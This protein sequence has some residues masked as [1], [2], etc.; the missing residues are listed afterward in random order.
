M[1]ILVIQFAPA[2]YGRPVPR[3]EPQLGTLLALL[4]QRGHEL[5][6]AGMP[7]F[8]EQTIK[9]ALARSLPQLVYADID[10]VCSDAARRT[11]EYIAGHEFLPVVAGGLLPTVLPTSVLSF[12]AV[13]AVAIG[14]PDASLVT[15]LERMKD[16]SVRQIVRGIWLRDE[17]GLARPELPPLV[18][19]LDSLPF[20]ERELFGY[21]QQVERT[22]EI[23]IAMG[24]GCPQRCGYCVNARV[25]ALYEGRGAWQRHRSVGN[26]LAEIRALRTAYPSARSVRFRDHA[27]ALDR[28]GLDEFLRAYAATDALPMRCHLRANDVRPIDI[29]RLAACGMAAADVELISGSDFI[30]NEVF[31]M[32]LSEE[33]IVETFEALRGA[34]VQSTATVYLGAPYESEVSLEETRE[35]LRRIRPDAVDVRP[36]HP[37]PG[38]TAADLARENGWAHP[39]GEEQ[40]HT[41]RNG[42]DM[43]TCRAEA[44]GEFV[45][46]LRAEFAT[47]WGEPWWRRWSNASRSALTQMFQRRG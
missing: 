25:R 12:P 42:V 29:A 38:T 10:L 5:A 16:P 30:R 36:Y 11:L 9:S 17:V 15:Y 7:R 40:F 3:F 6:L 28:A 8:D 31:A 32:E 2:A 24:R 21:A 35:L 20:A 4:R 18:E 34:G 19:D 45:R 26:V 27:F 23:E 37:F 33:R 46:K 1:R 13:Q 14:E 47:T 22:G 44:V 39:R 43:P 41:D